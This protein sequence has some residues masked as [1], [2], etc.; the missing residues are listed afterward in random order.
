MEVEVARLQ[1]VEECLENQISKDKATINA[2]ENEVASMRHET[3][4]Q[5]IST[6]DYQSETIRLRQKLVELQSRL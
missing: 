6:Q 5:R 2:L 1:Q 3:V 4:E